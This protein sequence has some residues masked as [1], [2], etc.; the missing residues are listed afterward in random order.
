MNV[1]NVLMEKYALNVTPISIY[2]EEIVIQKI[3][4]LLLDNM[5]QEVMMDLEFVHVNINM[6]NKIYQLI[7]IYKKNVAQ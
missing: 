3:I 5:D 7:N 1:F 6:K 4:V 2:E